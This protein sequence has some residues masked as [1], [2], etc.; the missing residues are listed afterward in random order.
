MITAGPEEA[1]EAVLKKMLDS[2]IRHLP[3]LAEK[4]GQPRIM[5]MVT[6]AD[7]VRHRLKLLETELEEL[8]TYIADLHDA[9]RD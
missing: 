6:L 1:V 8:K 9:D 5:G 7:L 3:V 4:D 2:D